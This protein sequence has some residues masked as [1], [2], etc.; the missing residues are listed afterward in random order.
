MLIE[1][2]HALQARPGSSRERPKSALIDLREERSPEATW[3]LAETVRTETLQMV[4]DLQRKLSSVPPG[5]WSNPPRSAVVWP[6]RSDMAHQLAGFLVLGLSSRLHFDARYWDFC[7]LV[8]RPIGHARLANA[9]AYEAE[10]KRAEALAEIDLAKTAFFS[11][12]SHEF[13]TPLTL[14]A[15]PARR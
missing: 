9:R 5:P 3:P 8:T 4:E 11:N 12:V 13:R 10:R 6:I 2:R 14:D 1:S 15:W 7:E